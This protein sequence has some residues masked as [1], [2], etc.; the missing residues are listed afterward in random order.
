VECAYNFQYWPSKGVNYNTQD[1]WACSKEGQ[2]NFVKDLVDALKPLENV[3][4]ISYWFPEEA[5]NGDDTN[6]NTSKGT[7]IVSWQNRGFWNEN[8]TQSGHAI[9]RTGQITEGK[10]AAD[11]CAPY[12]MGKFVGFEP[13]GI[14]NPSANEGVQAVKMFRNGQLV[15]ER[16]GILYSSDG[17]RL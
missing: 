4:G 3:E 9:N 2:Y 7:V 1:V 12:Y 13:Q 11:V 16:N 6:W 5:G 17:K 8:A 15:I 10:T 14:T